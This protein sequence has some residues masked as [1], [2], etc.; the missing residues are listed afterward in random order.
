MWHP[1][2]Q[3]MDAMWWFVAFPYFHFVC[4][5][6]WGSTNQIV[7]HGKITYN[8]IYG[9]LIIKIMWTFH[10]DRFNLSLWHVE[11]KLEVATCLL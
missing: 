8:I 2:M 5:L 7:T 10:Y 1:S 9:Y 6:A 11:F 3:W 4:D